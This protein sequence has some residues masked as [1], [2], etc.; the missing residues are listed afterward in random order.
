MKDEKLFI[1]PD[2]EIV[3]FQNEDIITDSILDGGEFDENQIP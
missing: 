2:L 1:K 3:Y